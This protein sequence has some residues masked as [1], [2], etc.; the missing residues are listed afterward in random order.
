MDYEAEL[1]V[2]PD[3][4]I[5]HVVDVETTGLDPKTD[6]IVEIG[7]AKVD[8]VHETVG[9]L[10]TCLVR[11]EV[12]IP[13]EAS[14]V[15]HITDRHVALAPDLKSALDI[16]FPE[17][18]QRDLTFCAHHAEFDQAFLG[19]ESDMV[20]T[21]RLSRHLWPDAAH[22]RLQFLRYYLE[23]ELEE[24]VCPHRA[25]GDVIVTAHVLL[26]IV[27][28][29]KSQYPHLSGKFLKNG[30]LSLSN[31]PVLLK[32]VGFGKYK[33]KEWSEVPT[34]YLGWVSEQDFDRDVLHTVRHYLSDR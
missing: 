21:K 10:Q 32:R 27:E 9:S 25:R 5:L 4:Q 6:S 33:G 7:M 18:G 30:M 16:R 8:I 15:H 34:S 14:A 28:Q 17:I 11:P 2:K 12:S 23:L 29:V 31:S 20:C 1:E 13:H 19:I 24:E 26:R 22:H 3:S